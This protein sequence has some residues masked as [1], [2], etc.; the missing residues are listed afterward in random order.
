[1][2]FSGFFAILV[3]A[4]IGSEILFA[5][6]GGRVLREI[7]NAIGAALLLVWGLTVAAMLVCALLECSNVAGQCLH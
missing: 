1:M 7:A 2:L 3:F 4:V 6:R 5:V